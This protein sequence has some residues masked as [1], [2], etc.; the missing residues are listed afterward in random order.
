MK[1]S[2]IIQALIFFI[3]TCVFSE[4][5]P[6]LEK[7]D[8][9]EFPKVQI[10]VREDRHKPLQSESIELSEIH[11]LDQRNI[12]SIQII[13]EGKLRK[14]RLILSI[15]LTDD[16]IKNNHTK[17]MTTMLLQ[18][19][20]E[21]DI[22]G[23]HFYCN[24]TSFLN[25]DMDKNIAISKIENLTYC[26]GNRQ[27]YN[28]KFLLS[29]YK[30]DFLPTI[31]FNINYDKSG[32]LDEGVAS[33]TKK[34][35]ELKIPITIYGLSEPNSLNI[36]DYTHANFYD[37]SIPSSVSNLQTELYLFR[38]T[39]PMIE[40]ESPFYDLSKMILPTSLKINLKLG[41]YEYTVKYNISFLYIVKNKM[42]N[43][44]YFFSVSVSLLLTSLFFIYLLDRK[45]KKDKEQERLNELD[46][47]QKNDIY[48]QANQDRIKEGTKPY[49]KKIQFQIPKIDQVETISEF[50]S[51]I[52]EQVD[53]DKII[54]DSF[55]Y[56]EIG[57]SGEAYLS[58]TLIQKIGPNPGR[59]F[60]INKEEIQIG[61]EPSNDL[62]L[63]DSSISD[64]HAKIKIINGHF[65]IF[66]NLSN[67]GV[68]LNERK[69]LRPKTLTDFDEI[70][71]GKVVLIFK[72]R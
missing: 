58:G 59:Q 50:K 56:E 57:I 72:G 66:D 24:E 65:V 32:P 25:L 33:V 19:L 49:K 54:E 60:F 26:D 2:K 23:L 12:Q 68:Y 61:R 10:Q 70:K 40:Y 7:I 44:N 35:K 4:S 11:D 29:Q 42:S 30:P 46:Y 31:L 5:K 41:Q 28:L 37:M 38:K 8:I 36:T 14:I 62:V 47:L 52:E 20:D 1:Y 43:L 67:I 71:I 55:L 48:F 27:N 39:P 6:V 17:N 34:S 16:R 15:Q 53:V 63:L 51:E 64:H 9:S 45:I 13:R 22:V 18:G 3:C 69:L 21:K